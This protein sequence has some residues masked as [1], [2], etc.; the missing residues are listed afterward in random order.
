MSPTNDICICYIVSVPGYSPQW[1]STG[2]RDQQSIPVLFSNYISRFTRMYISHSRHQAAWSDYSPTYL[3]TTTVSPNK[4]IFTCQ[5]SIQLSSHKLF[6][7]PP[8]MHLLP[9]RTQNARNSSCPHHDIV[10][11]QHPRLVDHPQHHIL[12]SCSLAFCE[13]DPSGI[14]RNCG[15]WFLGYYVLDLVEVSMTATPRDTKQVVCLVTEI[16]LF[17]GWVV[18]C[19]S[20]DAR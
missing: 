11:K 2:F 6:P 19:L 4:H 8:P 5:I 13:M 17:L 14:Q 3:R 18:S 1:G 20:D 10:T 9:P 7:P 16:F 15:F 12:N